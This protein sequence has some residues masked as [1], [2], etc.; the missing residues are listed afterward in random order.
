M[1]ELSFNVD[2]KTLSVLVLLDL[3]A[4]VDTVDHSFLSNRHSLVGLSGSVFKWFE[5]YLTDGEFFVSLNQYSSTKNTMNCGT[6]QGL[7]LGPTHF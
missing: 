2:E 1:N 3:S 6:P 5:S 7:V 4:V